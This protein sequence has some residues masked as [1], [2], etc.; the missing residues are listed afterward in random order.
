LSSD[1]LQHDEKRQLVGENDSLRITYNFS[2]RSGPIKISVYNKMDQPVEIDWKKS[3][4]IIADSA[5]SFFDPAMTITGELDRT[6]YSIYQNITGTVSP[7]EAIDFIP[8]KSSITKQ[9]IFVRDKWEKIETENS[10]KVK[11]QGHRIHY[12]FSKSNS[13]MIFRTY[14]TFLTGNK[15]FE[16][17]HRFYASEITEKSHD[18]FENGAGNQFYIKGKTDVGKLSVVI[19]TVSLTVLLIA[20]L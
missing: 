1:Q 14:L 6:R 3:A 2:G 12:I 5:I 20:A 4:M 10:M 18:N 7:P 8:P 19:F 11:N 17:E 16:I 9:K 15:S 13:P